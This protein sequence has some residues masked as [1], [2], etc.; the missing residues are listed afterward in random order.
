M[1]NKF[2][3]MDQDLPILDKVFRLELSTFIIDD[4]V[5]RVDNMT[6]S[7]ALEARVPFLDIELI[8]FMLSVKSGNKINKLNKYYLKKLSEKYL[9]K[10]V[11]YRDK[12]YFPVPPLKIIKDR[13]LS[14][15]HI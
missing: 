12:F 8:K 14:L 1:N 6:M 11:I 7:H 5:K 10:E 9:K 4:P 3:E 15:I 2:K 13:F